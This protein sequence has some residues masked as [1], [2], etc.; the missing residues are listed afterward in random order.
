MYNTHTLHVLC[1]I[2]FTFLYTDF[3]PA[4]SKKSLVQSN[5]MSLTYMYNKQ[6]AEVIS[7]WHSISI[8]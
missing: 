8:S 4:N 5:R 3:F 7:L 1:E 2:F 6:A